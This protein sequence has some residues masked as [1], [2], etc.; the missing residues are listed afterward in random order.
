MRILHLIQRYHPAR[1]GAEKHLEEISTY[2][3]AAGHQ[4]T[5]ITTD[6]LDFELFWDSSRRRIAANTDTEGGVDI[7][8]FPVRHVALSPLAYP[9]LRRLLSIMSKT[10]IIPTKWM[11]GLAQYTPWVPDLWRWIEETEQTYD[12]IAGMTIGFEPIMAVGQSFA[13]RIGAPF[14]CYP[15]THL[16]AG[17]E[18]GID[19]IS[20]FYTMRHQIK[21]VLDSDMVVAQTAAEQRFFTDRGLAADKIPIVGPGVDPSEVVGGNGQRFLEKH[22]MKNPLILF[23]GYLSRDKG[24][25][26]TV[27]ATRRLWSQ[28]YEVDLVLIGTISTAFRSYIDKLVDSDRKRIHLLGPVNDSE[29]RDALAAAS[30]LSMPSRTDS[31]GITYLEAWL[32]NLPVIASRTWGVMDVVDDGSDGLIAPFGDI[33]ALVAAMKTLLDNPGKAREMGEVGRKKVYQEHLWE[34]KLRDLGEL[35][36]EITA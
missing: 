32:Y 1:G 16:G 12:V 23:I 29:K 14:I 10:A 17:P 15:L 19:P 25:F 2:F 21:I 36:R 4:V 26:D 8:R 27:E 24:A 13:H 9:G 7:L 33:I 6:A 22:G 28:G 34:K 30:M 35:Y 5:V 20:R 18:P 31:F 3:A 11:M